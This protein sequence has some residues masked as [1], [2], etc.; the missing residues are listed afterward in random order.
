MS[1]RVDMCVHSRMC[2]SAQQLYTNVY[3][4]FS[5]VNECARVNERN[6][7]G[8]VGEQ[9]REVFLVSGLGRERTFQTSYTRSFRKIAEKNC[10]KSNLNA[11]LSVLQIFS[12]W[13]S[14][15]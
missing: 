11:I 12:R 15:K 9:T 13:L 4:L 10:S 14:H 2:A 1:T 7:D 3:D 5:F 8:C 6:F